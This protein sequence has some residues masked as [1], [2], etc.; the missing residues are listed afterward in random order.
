MNPEPG[1]SDWTHSEPK[2]SPAFTVERV[3]NGA[4]VVLV[5]H[6]LDGF[7]QF[8]DD[9]EVGEEDARFV[10][11]GKLLEV[12]PSLAEI[13][14]LPCGFSAERSAGS[15]WIRQSQ[16]P[17]DWDELLAE[18]QD[19][20]LERAEA[21]GELVQIDEDTEVEYSL[22]DCAL[23]LTSG[24]SVIQGELVAVGSLS[25]DGLWVWG[26]G[27]PGLPA[28][29]TDEVLAVKAFGERNQLEALTAAQFPATD[30]EARNVVA[31]SARLLE[32]DLVLEIP[33]DNGQMFVLVFDIRDV[34][35]EE[36][37]ESE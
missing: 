3:L 27:N 28:E 26:W 11:L 35:D 24:G 20:V 30:E 32:G 6:D 12:D 1:M 18:S 21:L 37:D 9:A 10:Q 29:A 15:T 13:I 8:L 34:D 23:T 22:E 4:P 19:Y 5:H 25:A 33:T 14:D 36:G 16:F 7:W 17:T 2:T 31:V